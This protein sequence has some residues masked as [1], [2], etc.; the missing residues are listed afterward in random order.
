MSDCNVIIG[1]TIVRKSTVGIPSNI[2]EI[3]DNISIHEIKKEKVVMINLEDQ[4]IF[5][6]V[7]KEIAN[8]N[9]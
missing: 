6:E 4:N 3:I 7:M 9:R 8:G 1:S 5:L 2:Q